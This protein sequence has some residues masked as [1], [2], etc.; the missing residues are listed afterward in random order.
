MRLQHGAEAQMRTEWCRCGRNGI[1]VKP[2][3]TIDVACKERAGGM[4]T[5]KRV[6]AM[7]DAGTPRADGRFLGR[8]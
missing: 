7:L 2:S 5:Q 8:R 6:T 3:A 1:A 4:A